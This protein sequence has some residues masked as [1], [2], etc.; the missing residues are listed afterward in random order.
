MPAIKSG[1]LCKLE[2][3]IAQTLI[4]YKFVCLGSQDCAGPGMCTPMAGTCKVSASEV[5]DGKWC[6][7]SPTI[8]AGLAHS[9]SLPGT[10]KGGRAKTPGRGGQ[11]KER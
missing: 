7:D 1:I 6:S 9:S 11:S 8:C 5:A 2:G 10:A 4:Q 3:E